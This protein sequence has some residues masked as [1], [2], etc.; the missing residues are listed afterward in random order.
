MGAPQQS[1]RLAGSAAQGL[2]LP[3]PQL[4][5]LREQLQVNLLLRTLVEL[6]P[7][8]P[9]S[10][11]STYTTKMLHSTYTAVILTRLSNSRDGLELVCKQFAWNWMQ[12]W[13]IRTMDCIIMPVCH[14]RE[15]VW[16]GNILVW[17][18]EKIVWFWLIWFA[19]SLHYPNHANHGTIVWVM[20]T[21]ANQ[22]R[23]FGYSCPP[24]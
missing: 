23:R 21:K 8:Y 7:V 6:Q 2:R 11:W 10:E 24:M 3:A 13:M 18:S 22:L 19:V 1:Q 14:L 16:I 20:Q 5:L 9:K 17:M 15:K 12:V 4:Q